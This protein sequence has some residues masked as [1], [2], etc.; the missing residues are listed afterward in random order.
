M[1][2]GL[3]ERHPYDGCPLCN[4]PCFAI[5]ATA[6]CSAHPLWRPQLSSTMTWCKCH[7]CGHIF[8]DGYFT[9]EAQQIIFSRTLDGQRFGADFERQRQVSARIVERI[10]AY[11]PPPGHWFDVGFGN[12]SLLMTAQEWGYSVAGVEARKNDTG[13]DPASLGIEVEYGTLANLV[14]RD[15]GSGPLSPGSAS[16]VSMADSLE[17]MPYPADGLAAAHRLLSG[18]GVLFLSM[19]N[20]ESAAWE[21][22][23]SKKLN[24]YWGEIEHYH[25]FGRTRL[26]ALLEEMRFTPVHFAI[27][28]RYRLCMEVVAQKM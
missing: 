26:Y 23:S 12:G 11:A 17:H 2:T 6:D 9:E 4:S 19:P 28:E 21:I 16:I 10:A 27:S 5:C 20:C 18:E 1:E 24:P 13:S 7:D 8:T 3:L 22:S 25:N 14:D 15:L